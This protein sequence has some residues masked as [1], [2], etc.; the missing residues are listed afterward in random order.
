MPLQQGASRVGGGLLRTALF[1]DG[2]V[3]RIDAGCLPAPFL[4]KSM[5]YSTSQ[6]I[7][8]PSPVSLETVAIADPFLTRS[9][10]INRPRAEVFDFCRDFHNLPRFMENIES[11]EVRDASHMHWIVRG[12]EGRLVEWDSLVIEATIDEAISWA[13]EMDA[14]IQ[15]SGRLE[16]SDAPDGGTQVTATILYEQPSCVIGKLATKLFQRESSLQTYLD[17]HRFK[18]LMEADADGESPAYRAVDG[19]VHG[20]QL[21]TP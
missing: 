12:T 15:N 2:E 21:P 8:V 1:Y 10:V 19:H 3:S 16:F 4:S 17:L 9:V 18:Q 7:D 14:S 5:P 11:V 6:D 13:S 20:M